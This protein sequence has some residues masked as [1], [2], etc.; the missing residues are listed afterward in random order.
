[1]LIHLYIY[2]Y[3][4]I[5]ICIYV[6]IYI[7]TYIYIYIYIYIHTYIYIC[8]CVFAYLRYS[9]IYHIHTF[10]G[11]IALT[12]PYVCNMYLWIHIRL[13]TCNFI[14]MYTYSI[15][16]TRDAYITRTQ[17][18]RTVATPGDRKV[19]WKEGEFITK[20][21]IIGGQNSS[22]G[23]LPSST[24]NSTPSR[25]TPQL[26]DYR[27]DEELKQQRLKVLRDKSEGKKVM[28]WMQ[29]RLCPTPGAVVLR[30]PM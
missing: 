9:Y 28:V 24:W 19:S 1:M 27:H 23:G 15:S 18:H 6:Y 20:Q 29:E 21:P 12:Y 10:I 7:Y 2:T 25:F 5:C 4:H 13:C 16:N 8:K 22:S 17:T 14:F 26:W 30:V 11:H 3:I